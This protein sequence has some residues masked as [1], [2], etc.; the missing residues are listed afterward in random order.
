MSIKSWCG[1]SGNGPASG[2][3]SLASRTRPSSLEDVGVLLIGLMGGE[4]KCGPWKEDGDIWL[5][6]LWKKLGRRGEMAV[7]VIEG[8]DPEIQVGLTQG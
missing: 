2:N 1:V 4:E 7:E 6:R 8:D 5:L 3:G